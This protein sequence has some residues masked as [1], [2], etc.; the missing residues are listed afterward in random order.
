MQYLIP[1]NCSSFINFQP[2]NPLNSD[3][4]TKGNTEQEKIKPSITAAKLLV[5]EDDSINQRIV[6]LTLENMGYEIDIANNGNQA[7]KMFL[8]NNYAVVLMDYGLPDMTG[9]DVAHKIRQFEKNKL[10]QTPIIALTAHGDFAK[11]ECLA[12]GMND[13]IAKPFELAR[14]KQLLEFW[15]KQAQ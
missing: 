8:L 4:S 9:V 14:F 7:L 6:Q 3:S 1:N 5:V 2:E 12:A 15:V 10:K 13:F 11:A